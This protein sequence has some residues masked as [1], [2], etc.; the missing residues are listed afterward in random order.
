METTSDVSSN[1]WLE[2]LLSES[3]E[4]ATQRART[5]FDRE[6]KGYKNRFVLLGAGNMGRR[7]LARLRQDGI[8]PL[9][10]T[11]NQSAQWGKTVDGLSVLPPEEAAARYGGDAVFIVTIYNNAHSFP[12]TRNQLSRLGCMKIVSVIPFRWKYHES[13]LP[14]Y[15]DDLPHK[16][17]L[18]AEAIRAALALWSDEPS[19]REFVAQVAWRLHGDFDVLSKPDT[20]QQ[21]F[22]NDLF[23]FMSDEFFVDIGAYDGDT[24]RKFLNIWG[25]KFRCVFA[26]EPDPQNFGKLV[27][28][29]SQ[30]PS[31]VANK[32]EARA[33]AASS[34]ACRLRF[35]NGEGTSA[36]INES[37]SI[38][39]NGVRLDDLLEGRHP[40]YIKMDVEGAELDAIEGCRRVLLEERPV[41]AACV[42]HVQDHLWNIPLAVNRIRPR[43]SFFL[44]PYA[45]ECWETV[46]YA[47]P[48]DRLQ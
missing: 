17:L 33:L 21:Y 42:Y 8:E 14:Y 32:I 16:V 13:F 47:V 1:K 10:F 18:Q 37:G 19:R 6:V 22:P 48:P 27:N 39:V 23:C 25:E 28:Y 3:P 29:L 4:A 44:R 30:L 12:D 36:A 43:N 7:I 20:G 40:T 26:L 15:R 35:V 2:R 31:A 9:A 38:E 46:C 24:I 45:M 34:R 11:D 41:L 5:A